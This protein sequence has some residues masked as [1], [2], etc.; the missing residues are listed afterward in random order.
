VSPPHAAATATVAASATILC[1][2]VDFIVDSFPELDAIDRKDR[3]WRRHRGRF[4]SLTGPECGSP[5]L[6]RRL[7][8]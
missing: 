6:A 7:T 5:H 8:N 4:A 3:C 2:V 1:I